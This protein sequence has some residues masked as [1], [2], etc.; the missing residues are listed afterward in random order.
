MTCD[1]VPP[2]SVTKVITIIV[3]TITTLGIDKVTVCACIH[4]SGSDDSD[5]GDELDKKM[6]DLDDS[7]EQEAQ[8]LDKNMWAPE[9][10]ET[11][12]VLRNNHFIQ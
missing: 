6:G 3:T 5:T 4:T 8:Q 11:E 1:F 10:E 12:E 7:K 2:T 9:E